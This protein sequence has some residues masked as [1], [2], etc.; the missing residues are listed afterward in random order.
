[1]SGW[2]SVNPTGY[3][4]YLMTR[5]VTWADIEACVN[6]LSLNSPRWGGE[7]EEFAPLHRFEG[8]FMCVAGPGFQTNEPVDTKL[9]DQPCKEKDEPPIRKFIRFDGPSVYSTWPSRNGSFLDNPNLKD[10]TVVLPF[11][12]NVFSLRFEGENCKAWTKWQCREYADIIGDELHA[13]PIH[14][15]LAAKLHN[16]ALMN[17]AL[18]GIAKRKAAGKRNVQSGSTALRSKPGHA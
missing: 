5:D 1:M 6:H 9:V 13:F 14:G 8:G 16:R 10:T 11:K 17:P 3:V 4:N 18:V 7:G 15:N 2:W 12:G